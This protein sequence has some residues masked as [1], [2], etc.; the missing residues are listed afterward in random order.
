M[1]HRCLSFPESGF[2]SSSDKNFLSEIRNP[3]FPKFDTFRDLT[4]P[5]FL[6]KQNGETKKS[7]NPVLTL[8]TIVGTQVHV[9]FL[10]PKLC[11]KG[12]STT[13]MT[14]QTEGLVRS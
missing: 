9:F 5:H 3:P 1:T 4:L 2:I 8:L 7:T 6:Q 11:V 10:P 13:L 14:Y 12:D